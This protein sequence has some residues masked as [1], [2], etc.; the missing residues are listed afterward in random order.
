VGYDLRLRTMGKLATILRAVEL[1][2]SLS[3]S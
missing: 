3:V 2:K 1:R